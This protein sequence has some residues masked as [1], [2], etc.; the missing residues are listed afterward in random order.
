[1]DGWSATTIARVLEDLQAQPERPPQSVR[2]EVVASGVMWSEDG[3]GFRERGRKMELVVIQDEHSRLKPAHRLRPGPADEE[4]V[5]NDL[6]DAIAQYGPPLVLMHDGG[7]TFHAERIRSLLEE[8]G[9]TDLTGS[10]NYPQ[11][12]GK[13]E[14]SMRDIRSYERAMRRHGG[15]GWLRDRLE[16]AIRDLTHDRPRPVLAGRTAREAYDE[17]RRELPDRRDFVAEIGRAETELCARARSR[18]E[19]G[20]ARRRAVEQALLRYGLVTEW[21]DVS[22]ISSHEGVTE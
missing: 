21:G 1:L 19:L 13:Q 5:Y 22:R 7:S 8:Y 15:R 12:N 16:A 4:S 14:R 6:R 20:T 2:Y 10:R 17:E 18:R 9:I 11:Y 3:T